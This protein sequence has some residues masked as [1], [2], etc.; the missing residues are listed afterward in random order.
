MHGI[1]SQSP[2][3][4][5]HKIDFDSPRTCR[6]NTV[7]MPRKVRQTSRGTDLPHSLRGNSDTSILALLLTQAIWDNR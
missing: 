6:L 5:C 2:P 3:F 7:K 1:P 4:P